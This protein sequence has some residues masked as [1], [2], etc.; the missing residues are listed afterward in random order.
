L[1][2]DALDLT[3]RLP[4]L[5]AL[6]QAGR[7][8][9]WRARRIAV[10]T[11]DLS[12]VA[13][14][15]ADRLVCAV[16]DRVD[17]VHVGALIEEARLYHDPDRA[18]EEERHQLTHRGVW[19]HRGTRPATTDVLMTMDTPDALAFD[20]TVADLAGT[21][22]RLG[23]TATLDVRRARAAGLLASPQ[24]AL[25][26]LTG[27]TTDL[28]RVTNSGTGSVELFVHLTPA[29]LA[30]PAA[31]PRRCRDGGEARTRHHRRDRRLGPSGHRTRRPDPHPT[32][33]HRPPPR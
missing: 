32:R 27:D 19:L 31:G 11:R 21:L 14:D 6:A 29:D 3:C 28:D 16:P 5:W 25:D 15:Y 2:A 22:G 23:D 1:L 33:P 17:R 13:A 30:A 4:R 20:H 10:E 9:V 24:T 7:V 12:V 18:A 8:A 26:L